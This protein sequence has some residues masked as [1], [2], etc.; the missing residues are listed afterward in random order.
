MNLWCNQ[1]HTVPLVFPEI[2]TNNAATPAINTF[3]FAPPVLGR[4]LVG[5]TA[6][7][8][9]L[10]IPR[11]NQASVSFERQLNANTMV[12]AGYL[13]AWGSSL[14]R[15]RLVNNAQPGPGGV[16]PR[17][18]YQTISFVP[19]TELGTL[20]PGVTV[21]SL[22][23]PVGPINLLESSGRSEY[24]SLWLLG[25]RTFS[26]GLSFLASYTYADSMTDSPSFRSPANEAEVPQNSFDP[27]ADWGPSGCDVTHRFVSSVI[28]RIPYAATGGTSA[29]EKFVRGVLGG[30][31]ASLIYQAQ[32]VFPFT[33]GV[34]SDTANAGSLLNVNPIRANVVPGVSPDLPASER[35]ADMW[36]NTAAFTTPPP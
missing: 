32:S 6:I 30:W 16:Q 35:S 29:G 5:F 28:Y 9:H 18:P 2:Q 20:P 10:Q 15:S 26:R 11:I 7:D 13:G 22:T 4:T 17:R 27:H 36:F 23:F 31:Q 3:G 14:D 12:Q 24:H 8:T 1:V 21:Q 19:N 34:F 33:I 25:K